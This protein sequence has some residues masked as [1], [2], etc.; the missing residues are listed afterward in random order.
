M[1][2]EGPTWLF[3]DSHKG[4]HGFHVLAGPEPYLERDCDRSVK[5]PR[6]S[7]WVTAEGN[8]PVSKTQLS[9]RPRQD[10]MTDSMSPWGR[11]LHPD[12]LLH[13]SALSSPSPAGPL[14]PG[15]LICWQRWQ[16]PM[17]RN[18]SAPKRQGLQLVSASHQPKPVSGGCS[19]GVSACLS[20][21]SPGRSRSNSVQQ[22]HSRSE[23]TQ[24][25]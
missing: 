5:D 2:Q 6:E 19:S 15:Q 11:P 17:G 16:D 21:L 10:I 3:S 22:G 20:P 23:K 18:T 12:L 9:G 1:P 25:Q 7:H 24:P 8:E 4:A 13:S 14:V